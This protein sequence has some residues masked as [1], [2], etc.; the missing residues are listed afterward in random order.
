MK[1]NE[2]IPQVALDELLKKYDGNTVTKKYG[3]QI[4][5]KDHC[6]MQKFEITHLPEYLIL[7]MQRFSKTDALKTKNNTIVDFPL[8][9]LDRGGSNL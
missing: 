1:E 8:E 7:H 5:N 6:L 9:D 4:E 2:G 3:R